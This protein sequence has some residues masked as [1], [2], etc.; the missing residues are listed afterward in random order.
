MKV[1]MLEQLNKMKSR[2]GASWLIVPVIF[3]VRVRLQ[4]CQTDLIPLVFNNAQPRS[5]GSC[6]DY[7]V[8]PSFF[9]IAEGKLRASH[10]QRGFESL[11]NPGSQEPRTVFQANEVENA[12]L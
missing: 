9:P 12:S 8:I 7:P 11:V 10:P 1:N 6:L 4:E 2:A 5:S 3:Q